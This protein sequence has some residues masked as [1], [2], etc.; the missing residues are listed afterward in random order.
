MT[1]PTREGFDARDRRWLGGPQRCKG[2]TCVRK[3]D[4]QVWH[5]LAL[6][7]CRRARFQPITRMP[8]PASIAICQIQRGWRRRD[9][10]RQDAASSIRGIGTWVGRFRVWTPEAGSAIDS[11]GPPIPNPSTGRYPSSRWP[12]PVFS[13]GG[14]ARGEALPPLCLGPMV[15]APA[16]ARRLATAGGAPAP[17][18]CQRLQL[19]SV[20]LPVEPNGTH[21]AFRST[22]TS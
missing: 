10:G 14:N 22:S 19:P 15:R 21:T 6:Q 7:A 4:V 8:R 1:P 12:R 9:G 13:V 11:P 5:D 20:L 16:R 17:I 3:P 2:E 18:P